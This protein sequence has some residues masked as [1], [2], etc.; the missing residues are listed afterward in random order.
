M[1]NK[2]FTKELLYKICKEQNITLLREY[3]EKELNSQ[4]FIDFKC[5]K[6]NQDTSKRFEFI[7]KYTRRCHNCS[8]SD[9]GN[10]AK[11]TMLAKYGVENISQLDEIKNKKK[12]TT[13][14]NYGVEHNSQS[15]IIKNK[16][17]HTCMSN[18]GVQYPQQSQEIRNKS[19][20][21]CLI[22]Y[23]VVHPSQSEEIKELV[24]KTN[25][26]KYGFEFASQSEEFKNR[27][28]T[29]CLHNYG[30]QYPQQSQEI[31]NKSKQ[32][33]VNNYG[34]EYPS[35][36]QE[37]KEKM[38]KTNKIKYGVNHYSQTNEFKE[39]CKQT[40]LKKY[41]VENPHQNEEIMEKSSKKAYKLKTYILPSGKEI[42]CQGYEPFALD[43][44]SKLEDENNII[45]GAKNVPKIWYYDLMSKKRRHYVDIFISN[46]NKCIEVKSTW[47]FKKKQD[48]VFEKQKAAKELGYEYEIWVYD[49]NGNKVETFI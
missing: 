14:K 27:V 9:K 5:V 45:T 22:N 10:K 34:V 23:G 36:S 15:D 16:K 40:C 47:T 4:K 30:V 48:N 3:D 1:P 8:Y 33:C 44:I 2:K 20:K 32:T 46:K 24:K 19:K 17:I 29:T 13:L 11:K 7:I 18:L 42:K 12:E 41:G 28:K 26:K 6:C 37:I 31:R 49:K 25:L 21:T 43:E 35:Q 38:K 39:K